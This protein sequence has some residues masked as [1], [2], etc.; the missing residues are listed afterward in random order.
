MLDPLS[1][2]QG[3]FEDF[4]LRNGGSRQGQY[5]EG[6]LPDDLDE[7]LVS[8]RSPNLAEVIRSVNKFS[9]NVMTRQI[10]LTM[11]AEHA[12][13][14]AT[15]EK[16]RQAVDA[17]LGEKGLNVPELYL[18]NGSGLSRETRISAESLGRVL[19]EARRSLYSSEF[20]A[21]MALAGMDGTMRR[22]F[23]DSPLSGRM[24]LK[25]GRLD[26]VQAVAGYV[27]AKDG[28]EYVV[29][30]L[31]NYAEAHRGLGEELQNAL[32]EWVY[33]QNGRTEPDPLCVAPAVAG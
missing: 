2:T 33:H 13:P 12:G 3:L 28:Q 1:Y 29:V 22:R 20:I 21:S 23:R 7:P 16:G 25:S 31:Q 14:P 8:V 9:N 26:H 30:I 5:R 4:W 32:L 19:L 15:V 18:E 11:G 6:Q 17:T 27:I 24:H 10:L